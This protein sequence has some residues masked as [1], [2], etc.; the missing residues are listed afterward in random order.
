MVPKDGFLLQDL[1]QKTPNRWFSSSLSGDRNGQHPKA[2]AGKLITARKRLRVDAVP[3]S[4]GLAR[5]G[6]SLCWC[7]EMLLCEVQEQFR[8]HAQFPLVLNIKAELYEHIDGQPPVVEQ[9]GEARVEQP[10]NQNPPSSLWYKF[11]IPLG[12]VLEA[13]PSIIYL[14]PILD[15]P[16]PESISSS[17][18]ILVE[19]AAIFDSSFVDG[20]RIT[21]AVFHAL[22]EPPRTRAALAKSLST[23]TWR[24]IR[25]L[26][27]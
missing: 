11:H 14:D 20:G 5:F 4:T 2:E 26:I 16:Q 24:V 23:F 27:R 18:L 1:G 19:N 12:T 3:D 10:N 13:T 22:D 8:R 9:D 21:F 6:T 17:P 7:V 25:P 15:F